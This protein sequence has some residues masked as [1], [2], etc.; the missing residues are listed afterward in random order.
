M[1][2]RGANQP[3]AAAPHSSSLLASSS[4]VT[5]NNSST[6]QPSPPAY[7]AQIRFDVL[8]VRAPKGLF[9]ESDK[10]WSHLDGEVIPATTAT[11]LQ[12][13][14]LRVA[15]G[16]LEAWRPIKA[17]LDAEP[18]IQTLRSALTMNNGLP[19][20]LELH[21]EPRDQLFFLY[22]QDGTLGGA[23][24]PASINVLRIEYRIP[25]D[26][27]NALEVEVMPELQPQRGRSRGA[28]SP[29]AWLTEAP[30]PPA[31]V[32]RE[33]AFRIVLHQEEF[34]A[35]GPSPAAHEIPY[36]AGSLL[37]C[38]ELDGQRYESVFFVTPRLLQPGTARGS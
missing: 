9:S 33:L 37:L 13:N 11:L 18:R 35:I 36:L 34:V 19:F 1:R 31:R 3:S 21:A 22:R 38:Q 23:P 2:G 5:D 6:A 4:P 15:R 8:Q 27:A 16:K 26:D 25:L 28:I 32:V 17:L 29:E 7:L 14:G 20:R 10:V 24:F 30:F 12:R